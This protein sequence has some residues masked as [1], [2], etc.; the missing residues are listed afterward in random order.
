M[1]CLVK[2]MVNAL[3][4]LCIFALVACMSK[5]V[6][7]EEDYKALVEVAQP[8]QDI[9]M[10]HKWDMTSTYFLTVQ[11]GSSY[12][13][14]K[15]LRIL[16]ANPAVGDGATVYGDF[17]LTGDAKEYI[18]FIAPNT[19]N[20]FY[21]ALI[22]EGGTYTI[23]T[24]TSSDRSIDFNR[25][26]A[27][28]AQID[29]R[30]VSLQSFSYCFEDEMPQ[31]GDYD[32]NDVVLRVSHER[33][34]QNQIILN[35]T[36]AAVGS[37]SQVA[38]AIRLVDYK[39]NDIASVTTVDDESFDKGYRKSAIPYIESNDLLACGSDSAAVI[40]VF[41]DAHWATGVV[42]YTS[43]GYIPRYKYNVSKTTSEE[44]DMMSPRTVSFIITFKNPLLLNYF[45]FE[46]LDPFAIVQYNGVYME[47]HAVYKYKSQTV[48]HEYVQPEGAAILPW[49]LVVPDGS[50]RYP[51][52]GVHI[53]YAK[54]GAL[55]G[56]YMTASHSFGQWASNKNTSNDWYN[57]PTANMVY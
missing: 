1:K 32:Y 7:N 53:G 23:T 52:D 33:T 24:F 2:R 10:S 18:A 20:K 55:F 40:N 19:Q 57:Y 35:I 6:F 4:L 42:A 15:R 21:A 27:L 31:P 26:V 44:H 48:F 47:N 56:A 12:S 39:Y 54:D 36:L 16:S 28:R 51:L 50:F 45:T 25:P 46:S 5:D 8:V 41:E 49:A 9:D 3:M 30:L 29:E 37:L 13:D 14:M 17:L 38:A 43:E 11:V 22:D 34:A